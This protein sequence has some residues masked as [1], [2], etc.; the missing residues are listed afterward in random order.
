MAICQISGD[1]ING[2]SW[3]TFDFSQESWPVFVEWTWEQLSFCGTY[4]CVIGLLFHP[5]HYQDLSTGIHE[6]W[7]RIPSH[8]F[9]INI[10][11]IVRLIHSN[12]EEVKRLNCSVIS[13]HLIPTYYKLIYYILCNT[14]QSCEMPHIQ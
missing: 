6:A 1:L 7:H 13:L 10:W 8:F 12:Q 11:L 3:L 14:S 9:N 5:V 2:K 4:S